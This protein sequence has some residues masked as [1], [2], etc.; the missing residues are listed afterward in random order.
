LTTVFQ[1]VERLNQLSICFSLAALLVVFGL[2]LALGLAL[3]R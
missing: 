1:A 3:Q 2:L